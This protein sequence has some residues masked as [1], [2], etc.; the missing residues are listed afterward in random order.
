MF[1]QD[2]LGVKNEVDWEKQGWKTGV[3]QLDDG[4]PPEYAHDAEDEQYSR[5]N[6][7]VGSAAGEIRI[8]NT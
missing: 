3:D 1:S 6:A 5:Q 2:H 4:V 8:R 7:Q